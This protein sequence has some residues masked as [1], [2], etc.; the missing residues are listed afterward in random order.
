[1]RVP[2]YLKVLLFCARTPLTVLFQ[3]GTCARAVVAQPL[4][5]TPVVQLTAGF[6]EVWS[7]RPPTSASGWGGVMRLEAGVE[8]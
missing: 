7:V 4:H 5:S 6:G 8:H 1:M 2:V 3:R